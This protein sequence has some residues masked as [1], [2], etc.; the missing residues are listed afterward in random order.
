[1][2]GLIN[3]FFVKEHKIRAAPRARD[4]EFEGA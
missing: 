4:L 1:V 2:G 3:Q